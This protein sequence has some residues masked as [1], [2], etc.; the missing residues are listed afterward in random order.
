MAA[1]PLLLVTSH[2]TLGICV[3]SDSRGLGLRGLELMRRS[4]FV[5]HQGTLYFSLLPSLPCLTLS[6]HPHTNAS[7]QR[8]GG[9]VLSW[10]CRA[11]PTLSL[12]LH[13]VGHLR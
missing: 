7:E 2:P 9:Y 5:P 11:Q 4:D 6:A 8:E 12:T 10:R 1:I 3:R 13:S